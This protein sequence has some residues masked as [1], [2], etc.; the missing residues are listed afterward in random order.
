MPENSSV[1]RPRVDG[2]AYQGGAIA[3]PNYPDPVVVDL[4]GLVIPD[5]LALLL[6]HQ[7]VTGARVGSVR[8]VSDDH[9][10]TIT[11]EVA[12][13]HADARHVVEQGLW[14]LSIGAEPLETERVKAGKKFMAN[15]REFTG[16]LVWVKRARLRE[17]SIVA[18]GADADAHATIAASWN[19]SIQ[20]GQAM[21]NIE[22]IQDVPAEAQA[23]ASD[24]VA[25]ARME[26]AIAERERAQRI[27][28]MCGHQEVEKPAGHRGQ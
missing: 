26:A 23:T 27:R 17:V 10:L 3:L 16:P 18:V 14:A 2:V 4:A 19:L 12:A 25:A 5:S 20:G 6:N 8:A 22:P 7:N 1:K 24:I 28:E 15:G 11:G 21:Y 9:I 13:T